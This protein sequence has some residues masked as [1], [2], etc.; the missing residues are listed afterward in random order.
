MRPFAFLLLLLLAGGP[1]QAGPPPVRWKTAAPVGLGDPVVLETSLPAA[2]PDFFVEGDL[3]PGAEWGE[4]RVASLERTPPS[5]FP[6]EV[7]LLVTLQVFAV[8]KVQLPPARLVLHDEKGAHEASLSLPPL[9]VSSLLPPGGGPQ[10]P[11]A[12]P[13]DV[14]RRFPVGTLVLALL[15]GLLLSAAVLWIRRRL[16]KRPRGAVQPPSL[17]ETDPHRWA[18]SEVERL[19]AASLPADRR[20]EAL[21][22]VLRAFLA[23]RYGLPFPEWTLEEIRRETEGLSDLP[24]EA[25]A[26]YLEVLSACALVLYARH[27][28]SA[29]ETAALKARSLE[30]VASTPPK[31][32]P[33][34]QREAAA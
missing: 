9:E 11:P 26:A 29:G 32:P 21:S 7:R 27:L 2:S 12:P 19:F 5:S 30:A 18:L 24:G 16:P 25:R 22:A 8:G 28:P 10:P 3:Y 34:R 31:R 6:G 1:A 23:W 15:A 20:F 4:A 14:P 17:R 33:E 13:L